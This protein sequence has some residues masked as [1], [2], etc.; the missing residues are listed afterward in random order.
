MKLINS[1]FAFYGVS[2]GIFPAPR[3][4]FPIAIEVYENNDKKIL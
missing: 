1:V 4:I 2:M 3:V